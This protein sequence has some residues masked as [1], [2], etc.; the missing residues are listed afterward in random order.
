M[1]RKVKSYLSNKPSNRDEDK[2]AE[3]SNGCEP[4]GKSDKY[5]YS[6]TC[7]KRPLKQNTNIGFQYRLSLNAGQKYY[8]LLQW[9]HSAILTTF[10]KLTFS[11]KTYVLS[12]FKWL[13]KTGFTVYGPQ[14]GKTCLQGS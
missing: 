9:E 2:L 10:I 8:R 6:K 5:H 3:A 4:P 14:L 7:I 13:L 11:N 1:T 12:I